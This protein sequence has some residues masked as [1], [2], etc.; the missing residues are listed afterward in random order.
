MHED[1]RKK[2]PSYYDKLKGGKPGFL[3]V[4]AAPGMPSVPSKASVPNGDSDPQAQE[5]AARQE[6]E[7][8]TDQRKATPEL[9]GLIGAQV[10]AVVENQYRDPGIT[11]LIGC[12][13]QISEQL[14][15]LPKIAEQMA[16]LNKVIAASS[17]ESLILG[18]G[19]G[20]P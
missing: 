11:E 5:Q 7:R 9:T 16:D 12:M 6:F 17:S 4:G 15:I 10:P 14:S 13:S 8:T 18:G 2:W 1:I 3:K 19:V 20:D